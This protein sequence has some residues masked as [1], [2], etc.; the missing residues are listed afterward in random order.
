M[1][2]SLSFKFL[3]VLAAILTACSQ[4]SNP[5]PVSSEQ[6]SKTAQ[7]SEEQSFEPQTIP[8]SEP[9]SSIPAQEEPVISSEP[10]SPQ[11]TNNT[12]SSELAEPQAPASSS[13]VSS[14][15]ENIPKEPKQEAPPA[16]QVLQEKPVEHPAEA[17]G[18]SEAEV[19]EV[20]A[21]GIAY[22]ESKGMTW[23]DGFSIDSS[24]YYPPAYSMDGAEIMKRDLFY[25]VD[26][27]YELSVSDSYYVDGNPIYYKIVKGPCKD[28]GGW[29]GY[30]LY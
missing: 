14:S 27:I 21:A 1:K 22:A 13:P 12:A 8:S 18:M 19:D 30:V 10:A 5:V 23:H 3:L 2:K 29:F 9:A 20:I 26:Q 7:S 16:K 6:T 25:L 15:S 17:D 28:L 24:G 11:V 4:P